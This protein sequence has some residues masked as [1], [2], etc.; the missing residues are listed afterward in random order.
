[1]RKGSAGF[2][3]ASVLQAGMPALQQRSITKRGNK[4]GARDCAPHY[5]VKEE[6]EKLFFHHF[7]FDETKRHHVVF[8]FAFFFGL[9][10]F[11]VKGDKVFNAFAFFHIRHHR[12]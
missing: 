7:D 6:G 12:N 9:A 1:M 8:A 10:A 4:K 3:P 2:Q 11:V 5:E